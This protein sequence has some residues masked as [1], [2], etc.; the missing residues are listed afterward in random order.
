[1]KKHICI[2]LVLVLL[3]SNLAVVSSAYYTRFLEIKDFICVYDKFGEENLPELFVDTQSY[4]YSFSKGKPI[5]SAYSLLDD[6]QKKFYSNFVNAE[7]GTLSITINFDYGEF[8]SENFNEDY[9][10][11]IMYAVIRD[12]PELFYF[13]G[14]GVTGGYYYNDGTSIAVLQCSISLKSTCTYTEEVL[15]EYCAA[16]EEAVKNI[17]IDLS[18]R[19][20]F[21]KTLHDYLCNNAYYPDLNSSDYVG[22]AHD[23]Y[24]AL[25]EGR[26]VCEGYS[27]AFKLVCDYYKIPCVCLTGDG[28]TS[29]GSG[30][31]MWNAVQMDDGNW[32]FLDITWDD[33]GSIIYYDF[34]LSGT[35][36]VC[37]KGFG[38][39]AFNISHVS[40][41]S[42]YLPVLSYATDKYTQSDHN[43]AFKAT[44]NSLVKDEGKYLV[45]SF[46]DADDSYVFYNGIY[47]NT[48]NL[49]TNNTFTVP[50]GEN[51][52]DENWTLVLLG[53]CNGD[54]ECN[55]LDY[56]AT[57]NKSLLDE[58]ASNAYNMASDIDCD[59][60]IDAI[61]VSMVYLLVNGLITEIDIE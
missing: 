52:A 2:L 53:D 4:Y 40:D 20:N 9:L 23:A 8:L 46:F 31:H 32:Y 50:S 7:P 16:L 61:D 33:Q 44:Y 22:N 58:S 12:H 24:G 10:S 28:V 15:P 17:D 38:G 48:N 18:N 49:T 5:Y 27:E 25:V 56:S 13:N 51:G 14:F 47:V 41:G 43:T 26:T 30:P 60:Y 59:G 45:R 37:S 6:C 34:F 11:E 35:N 39:N 19:Y 42:P 36:T 1:M 55:T 29:D 21:V 54:G 3:V 57:V